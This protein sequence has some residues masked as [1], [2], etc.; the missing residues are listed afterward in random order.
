MIYFRMF[1]LS[2]CYLVNAPSRA[3]PVTATDINDTLVTST[4]FDDPALIENSP[5]P[6]EENS[7]PAADEF[8]YVSDEEAFFQLAEEYANTAVITAPPTPP[9][10]P[11]EPI[12]INET[13][14]ALWKEID[15]LNE[16]NKPQTIEIHNF[17]LLQVKP[18][19]NTVKEKINSLF[20]KTDIPINW[21]I[22]ATWE[23]IPP[24][25]MEIEKVQLTLLNHH[26][27]EKVKEI[28]TKYFAENYNNVVHI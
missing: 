7:F 3:V 20:A 1:N 13:I 27:K 25:K 14:K 18:S 2:Q 5:P 15:A 24:H 6:L 21:K 26:V 4:T 11:G 16:F 28:L 9:S 12:D 17:H 19:L 23:T 10:L 22:S 8:E